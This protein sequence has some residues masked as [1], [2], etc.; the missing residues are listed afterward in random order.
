MQ[1][2][3]AKNWSF[4]SFL[5]AGLFVLACPQVPSEL[6]KY[7]DKDGKVTYSDKAPKKGEK[8]EPVVTD[9]RPT[10]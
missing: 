2:S 6:W 4:A 5:L 3:D 9:P 7:T 10:S 1:R 8:A